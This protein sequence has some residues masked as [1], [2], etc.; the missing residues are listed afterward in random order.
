MPISK[1]AVF[2][3]INLFPPTRYMGSKE[4]LVPY[5]YDIFVSLNFESALDLMS[6]TSVISYL[7]KCMGKET[8]S[9]DYMHMNYLA[10]KCLIENSTI[11]LEKSFAQ[12]LTRK[13]KTSNFIT[14][15]FEGLYFDKNNSQ[16]I[17]SIN[18][19]IQ[20]LDD[21]VEKFIAQTALI[22]ACI[23]KRHRGIF[24]YTGLNHDDGRKDL[25]LSINE[26]FI[27]NV[28]IIN[29]AIFDNKKNNKVFMKNCAEVSYMPDL[30]YI[31][32]PYFSTLSDNE[33][34]RRY[35]FVEGLSRNWKDIHFQE[36]TKTKKF[37]SYPS[38]FSKLSTA[39]DTFDLL[40]RKYAESNI[41]ISYSSN[42]KPDKLFFL[43]KLKKY[44]RY[45][46]IVSVY[47]RYSFSNQGFAKNRIKNKVREYIF[48]G[49]NR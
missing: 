12:T 30:V 28:N 2:D 35:H 21:S 23:K 41:V 10:A 48:I 45:V 24:A 44:K 20:L 18:N 11:R 8:I 25:R 3:Q 1:K 40:I 38:Q 37:K 46:D 17:D 33:Y 42:A 4:K 6:G 13:N 43:Q 5:L 19:N 31:D 14:N 47:Y 32:P 16:M 36:N 15:K 26:H 27:N 34:V 7:L 39:T 9:N 29:K 22:R 49:T